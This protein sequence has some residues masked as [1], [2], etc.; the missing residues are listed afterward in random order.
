MEGRG[1][2]AGVF[3]ICRS[4]DLFLSFGGGGPAFVYGGAPCRAVC[5]ASDQRSYGR[6]DCA[7]LYFG[8]AELSVQ[9]IPDLFKEESLTMEEKN[10]C[11]KN[12][13]LII[14]AYNE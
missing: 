6:E 13:L 4:T 8:A 11:M 5:A 9:Q 12:V 14:P 7:F 3:R 2:S 10:A 1:S